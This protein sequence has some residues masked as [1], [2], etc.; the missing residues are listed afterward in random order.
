MSYRNAEIPY[1]VQIMIIKI[2]LQI[3]FGQVKTRI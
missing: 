2:L 3:N 1:F